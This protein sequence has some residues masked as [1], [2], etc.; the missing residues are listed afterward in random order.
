M[1][2]MRRVAVI[3]PAVSLTVLAVIAA[4]HSGPVRRTPAPTSAEPASGR[5]TPTS[6]ATTATL[7]PIQDSGGRPM[8]NGHIDIAADGGRRQL[9]VAAANLPPERS[10]P[11]QAYAVWL[12]NSRRDAALLGFVVPPVGQ[13]GRFESHRDLSAQAGR[14]REIVVTLESANQSRPEGPIFL[15]GRLP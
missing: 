5:L 14:Y 7:R 2:A 1:R 15:R 4:L 6:S 12:F 13:S 10:H 3:V 8:P 9:T 11:R